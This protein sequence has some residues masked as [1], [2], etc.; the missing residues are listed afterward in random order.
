MRKNLLF[1]ALLTSILMNLNDLFAE[2][3]LLTP[4]KKPSLTDKEI[5]KK[6]SK[7]ILKP[8]KKPKKIESIKIKK[9]KII[10]QKIIKKVK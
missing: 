6:L 9:E 3:S 8:I 5:I 7:N 1:I 10:D 4:L 2:T